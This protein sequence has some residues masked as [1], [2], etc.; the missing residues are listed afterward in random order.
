MSKLVPI[1]IVTPYFAPQTHAAMFRVHKLVKLLPEFGY[2]PIVVTTDINYLY[3]EDSSLL[4]E[5]PDC[6]EII[7]TRYIEPSM[8]GLRMALGGKDR[9]FTSMKQVY[10]RKLYSTEEHKNGIVKSG[11]VT[12]LKQKLYTSLYNTPDAYWTWAKSVKP[13]VEELLKTKDIKHI[14]TTCCP[15]SHLKVVSEL[16]GRYEFKWLADFRD[17]SGYGYKNTPSTFMGR[18]MQRKIISDVMIKADAVTG[19]AESYGGIFSDLYGLCSSKFHFIPTA[20]DENYFPSEQLSQ[21]KNTIVF[22]GEVM[23]EQTSYIFEVLSGVNTRH[24]IDLLFIGRKEINLPIITKLV[25]SI[26]GFNLTIKFEDHIPQKDLYKIITS[27]KA[28]ILAPGEH[29]Y[30]WTNFAKLVDYIG[31]NIP[32]IA[33]VSEYSE[34]KKELEKSGN[35]FFILGDGMQADSNNLTAW[36]NELNYPLNTN[37]YCNRY[38]SRNMVSEFAKI[39]DEL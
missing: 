18:E 9:T 13:V 3:N 12:M 25:N 6:V 28:C 33:Y 17:P 30:W 32:V 16:K 31:L 36:L 38:H 20:V 15:Y 22:A 35:G 11:V 23:P 21:Y 1:L 5:L 27:A 19:L 29:K 8:R 34:A 4:S 7:R 26:D 39:L 37:D 24:K 14:Y 10:A 2:Q